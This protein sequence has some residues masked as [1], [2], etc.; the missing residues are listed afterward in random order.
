MKGVTGRLSREFAERYATYGMKVEPEIFKERYFITSRAVDDA[1][2][3]T[4]RK[5][6]SDGSATV[7]GDLNGFTT[8][9]S[10]VR[11]LVGW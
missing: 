7:F 4:I 8:K 1:P 5:V 3:Y 2:R 6:Q 9:I 10:A 11:W